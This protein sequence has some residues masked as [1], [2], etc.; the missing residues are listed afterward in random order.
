MFTTSH[1]QNIIKSGLILL[2]SCIAVVH[3]FGQ[4]SLNSS[5]SNA[6]SASGKV[7]F[8]VG[9]PYVMQSTGTNGHANGGIQQPFSVYTL[10]TNSKPA[11][12]IKTEVFPNPTDNLL[13]IR[14]SKNPLPDMTY[15]LT[16]ENQKLIYSKSFENPTEE[17][18][19]SSLPAGIYILT[20]FRKTEQIS[21]FK[22][23]K[24]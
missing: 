17:L 22:I 21:S 16:D 11:P 15:R 8:S 2:I 18:K 9:E 3:C 20:V 19:L 13:Y 6:S 12:D 5:S 1:I 14:L 24:H 7:S 10:G 4:T 23:V